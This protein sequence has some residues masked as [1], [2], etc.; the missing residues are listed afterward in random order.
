MKIG[1]LTYHRVPNFGA[2]LQALSTF[3]YFKKQEQKV[4]LIDWYP[5]DVKRMYENRV[6]K[7][8]IECHNR[9]IENFA[10]L[11]IRIDNYNDFIEYLNNERFDIIFIG[12][13]AVFKYLPI[14]KR[15]IF[16]LRQC[17]IIRSSITSDLDYKD[18]P[19]WGAFRN[20]LSYS[21][22]LL[23]FS[24]S[25]QN[26]AYKM[27]ND[28]ERKDLSECVS[29][30]SHITA[31]DKWTAKMVSYLGYKGKVCI[32]PDP[33]F[34]FNQNIQFK[35]PTKKEII[36]KYKL[37]DKYIL[38]SFRLS[39]LSQSYVDTIAKYF[40]DNGYATV[41]FPMPEG[42]KRFDTQYF[43]DVPLSPLDWYCLIK[44]SEGYI[45]ERMHPIIVCLHNSVPFF[46]FDEYGIKKTIIPKIYRYFNCESSKIYHILKNADM[47]EHRVG[48][49]ENKSMPSAK[50]IFH[51]IKNTDINHMHQFSIKQGKAY[52]N[53]MK[54]LMSNI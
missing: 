46:C 48:Y 50:K 53:S 24:V 16:N 52:F 3:S 28:A 47:L 42:L 43:I 35:L 10:D 37:P 31:R 11:S 20:D 51:I 18:N 40:E 38:L 12:S 7:E 54:N 4:L 36:N 17:R 29:N 5:K 9:F 41:S 23:G 22:Q 8:Q 6:A 25:C 26:T 45:G 21:P 34:S 19:F 32:T 27:L 30:F 14:K 13:D 44:Y 15:K 2:Q 39:L 49:F 1:V 33:V